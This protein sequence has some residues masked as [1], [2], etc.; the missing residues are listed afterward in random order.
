MYGCIKKPIAEIYNYTDMYE[1][2]FVKGILKINNIVED[3][4]GMLEMCGF[5]DTLKVLE[6]SEELLVRDFVSVN[7]LYVN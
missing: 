6:H 1:G 2:N 5:I 7:S 4:K 3:I